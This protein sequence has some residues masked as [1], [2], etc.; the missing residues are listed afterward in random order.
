M[1]SKQLLAESQIFE[2]EILSGTE[3]T[4]KPSQEMPKQDG[5]NHGLNLIETPRI[6]LIAKSF[7]LLVHEVLTRDNPNKAN[8]LACFALI[9]QWQKGRMGEQIQHWA[10][11]PTDPGVWW[12]D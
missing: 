7:I 2:D 3:R 6:K 8:A 12:I 9:A 11:R 5:P 10:D 1:Q 4:H